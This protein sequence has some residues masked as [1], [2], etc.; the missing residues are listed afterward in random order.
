MGEAQ[1]RRAK[2][3]RMSAEERREMV[4]QPVTLWLFNYPPPD[5]ITLPAS[6]EAAER[7]P[8]ALSVMIDIEREAWPCALCHRVFSTTARLARVVVVTPMLQGK[9][10]IATGVCRACDSDAAGETQ[11]R[12]KAA[13]CMIGL[14]E[15]RA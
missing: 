9:Y 1:R 13:F 3:F 12:V 6:V 14:P 2:D 10:T 7:D 15:G 4:G 11:R 5:E 8:R